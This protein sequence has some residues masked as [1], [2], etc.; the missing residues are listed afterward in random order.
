MYFL[1]AVTA[2]AISL[3]IWII[4]ARWI[5]LSILW[6]EGRSPQ[7]AGSRA[8]RAG[9]ATAC[10]ILFLLCTALAFWIARVLWLE[11]R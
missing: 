5:A 9:E 8:A 2:A 6:F 7:L 1:A 11:W 4:G 3:V 10:A